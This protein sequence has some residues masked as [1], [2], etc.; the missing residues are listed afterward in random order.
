MGHDE[1]G[2][3]VNFDALYKD[4]DTWAVEVNMLTSLAG[5]VR[6]Q[7]LELVDFGFAAALYPP[8]HQLVDKLSG[9]LDQ[10][11]ASSQHIQNSL[12]WTAMKYRDVDEGSAAD[13]GTAQPP[14]DIPRF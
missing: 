11:A 8:Y 12:R 4:A 6:A 2:N 5:R 14:Y 9:L 10:A 7:Q 3:N 13:I 1:K